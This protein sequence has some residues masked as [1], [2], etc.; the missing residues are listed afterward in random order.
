MSGFDHFVHCYV[1]PHSWALWL[2]F[3][4]VLVSSI[5]K[6]HPP[7]PSNPLQVKIDSVVFIEKAARKKPYS[8][9]RR[10]EKLSNHHSDAPATNSV[11]TAELHEIVTHVIESG[12]VEA[13]FSWRKELLAALY[14]FSRDRNSLL[15]SLDQKSFDSQESDVESE[16]GVRISIPLER[17][18]TYR[19]Y[20]W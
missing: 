6:V 4:P 10:F 13:A 11:P 19:M 15:G 7:D 9:L 12:T 1:C 14:F 3:N 16:P 20:R 8:F 18:K 5:R 2:W 17:I